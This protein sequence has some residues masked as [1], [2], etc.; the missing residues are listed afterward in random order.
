MSSA[1][2]SYS[3]QSSS[4][5][6]ST[7]SGNPAVESAVTRLLV[8]IKQLLEALTQWSTLKVDESHVSDVY[9][10]LGNDFNAAVAAFGVYNIDMSELMSVPDDLRNVLEQCLAEDATTENLEVYLPTVRQIITSLL[11]GLRDKQSTYR[12]IVSDHRH[13]SDQSGSDRMDSRSS[14]SSKSHRKQ[15]SRSTAESERDSISRRSGASSSGRRRDTSSSQAADSEASFVGGFS[16]MIP[17]APSIQDSNDLPNPYDSRQPSSSDYPTPR[18]PPPQTVSPPPS[19]PNVPANVKRYS[20]VDK[21]VSSPSPPS[22]VVVEPASPDPERN[23]FQ[24]PQPQTNGFPPPPPPPPPDSPPLDASQVPAMAISLDALKKS[25]ALERR[26]SKR[27]STYHISKMTGAVSRDRS[28]RNQSN[29]RS[30]A[31]SSALTPGEL[32]VLTEVDDEEES[33]PVPLTREGSLR[34]RAATPDNRTDTPPVPPL[35]ST[36][37]RTPEPS[38]SPGPASAHRSDSDAKRRSGSKMTVFLQLGR[39]VKKTSLEPGI[40]FSSLRMLFVDKFSYNPGQ[41][42]FPAIYIRDPSSGVQYELEAMDEVKEK[43][44]LSLNIEPLDQ[45]KQHIDIQISTLSQDIKELRSVVSTNQRHSHI[46]NIVSSPIA[47]STPAPSRPTDRQFRSVARRLS[48]LV[49]SVNEPS[50]SSAIPSSPNPILPQ[51]T[52]QTLQAQMTGGSILSDYS[53]RVVGDLKTQFDEVQNLRRD[54]GIMRQLY[55]EFM[56]QTKES[57]GTLRTQTQSVKQLATANVGGSRAFIDSGKQ[58]LDVRTQNVLT[59]V[60]RLQDTVESLKDDVLKRHITPKALQLKAV[61]KDMDN[62]AADLESLKEHIK[63][64]KPMWKKTWAEE[65]QN[66]VEEQQFL[67]HQE[68][69][70]G[71]L[72]EDHKGVVEIYGHV[73]QVI[74]LRSAGSGRR[75]NGRGF[76]PPVPEEGSQSLSNVMMEI[77][78]ASVDPAKRMKAIEASQKN[79]QKELANR[80]DEMLGE[81]TD[82]VAGKKLKM[83]GGAEEAERVRQ[84]RNDMTLKAMFT[85]NSAVDIS[86]MGSE[87]TI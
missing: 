28:V 58:K 2:Q 12:R 33:P 30:L 81:L 55:T 43:C 61:K 47:E 21:P 79:R 48:R 86:P 75:I 50:T 44:L 38:P 27:F 69:F 37:S 10:R 7:R 40:S 25:D 56:K 26:A 36:P 74:N 84:K 16:P 24:Q 73:E 70:L 4:S 13:R 80:G 76:K 66:I 51:M 3:R 52:G 1:A 49:S 59:E 68:E 23:D 83:T 78:T 18:S 22:V 87:D 57:L 14:R 31:V 42:N 15:L 45:I 72:L 32:A 53:H 82:F 6:R 71:D 62:I 39:E 11:Q 34:S 9:V 63:T 8:S 64:V 29:R 77:R 85:G 54:L 19:A 17:E 60:E 5:S 20:L 67:T 46:P 35:P 65:L 41:E